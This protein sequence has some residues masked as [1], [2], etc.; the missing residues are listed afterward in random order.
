MCV[1]CAIILVRHK[2]DYYS[3]KAFSYAQTEMFSFQAKF[4]DN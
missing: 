3:S 1:N 2:N 4:K